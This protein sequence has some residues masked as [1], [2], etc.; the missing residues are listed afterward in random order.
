MTQRHLSLALLTLLAAMLWACSTNPATGRSQLNFLSTSEEIKLGSQAQPQFTN[1]YGGQIPS[2]QVLSYVRNLGNRLAQVSERKDLPW[3]FNV[4][5]SPVIN[6]F[7]LPGGKVFITRGLMSKLDNEAQ[8]AGV[9]GHE[10]G[11]VTAQHIG[12]QMTRAMGLQIIGIGLGVAGEAADNDYLRVLGV[13]TTVGGTVYLLKFGR[14]QEDQ[15]DELGMRYMSK[16]G[17]NPAGQMQV[18]QVLQRESSG[19]GGAPEF[20][21]THPLPQSRV[22]RI[23]GLLKSQYPD[24]QDTTKYRL[25]ADEYKKQALV[26]LS[27]LP[28]PKHNPTN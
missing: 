25:A 22:K 15:A 16:L 19:S 14:D 18:M 10:V 4:L 11:H 8:L 12:Q 28:A 2:P 20:L 6:A 23:A 1:E 17:Y 21:S 26:P 13:G 27:K 24:H 7:A 9:L 3:E 5:D